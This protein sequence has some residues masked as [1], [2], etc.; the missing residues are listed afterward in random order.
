MQEILKKYKITN[1]TK[2]DLMTLS[3]ICSNYINMQ[4]GRKKI[5]LSRCYTLL[6]FIKRLY[7]RNFTA[8]NTTSMTLNIVEVEALTTALSAYDTINNYTYALILGV[9]Q[10]LNKQLS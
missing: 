1:L 6:Q 7:N 8:Q 5:E 2:T 9:M 4:H 10:E 3:V